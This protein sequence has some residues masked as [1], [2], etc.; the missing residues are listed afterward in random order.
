MALAAQAAVREVAGVAAEIKW[1]NDVMVGDRK[2]AGILAEA[3][4]APGGTGAIDAV[5]VGIGLNVGWTAA[6]PEVAARAV[7]LEELTGR[8][9]ERGALLDGLLR[10]LAPLLD[11]WAD[12]PDALLARYR[13]AVA[14][15]G[16]HVRVTF[17][18]REEEGQAVDLTA[19]GALVVVTAGGPVT[20]SAGDVVHL[21]P[22]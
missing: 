2:L 14:T 6:P 9:I 18:D 21:R 13:S 1:P 7:T 5:V 10:E 8:L 17:P 15:I 11:L 20:V 12:D 4:N 22:A 16:L 19:E 3:A